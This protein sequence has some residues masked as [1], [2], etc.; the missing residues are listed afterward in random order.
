LLLIEGI[1]FFFFKKIT[2]ND[3]D[4][5]STESDKRKERLQTP[6]SDGDARPDQLDIDPKRKAHLKEDKARVSKERG[7]DVNNADDFRDAKR[8]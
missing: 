2:K 3:H 1:A 8:S 5:K 4:M 7:A 6:V